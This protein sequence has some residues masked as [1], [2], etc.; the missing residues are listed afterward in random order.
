MSSRVVARLG[1]FMLLATSVVTPAL[2]GDQSGTVTLIGGDGGNPFV[3]I[4]SG[5]RTSR[6]A[7]AT[8][9]A[10]A[11][12]NPASD[13]AKG[14]L[15]LVMSAHAANKTINVHGNGLCNANFPNREEVA[16]LNIQ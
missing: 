4:V 3:F 5:T 15:S 14:L 16:W 11:I 12:P 9:D 2:A 1:A 13:N 10:W 7:C 8:D 6:P